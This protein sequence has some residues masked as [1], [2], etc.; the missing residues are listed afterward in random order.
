MM[1]GTEHRYV[2]VPVHV[3]T[4]PPHDLDTLNIPVSMPTTTTIKT[5]NEPIGSLRYIKSVILSGVK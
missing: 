3:G 5:T 2:A 1:I 4:Q